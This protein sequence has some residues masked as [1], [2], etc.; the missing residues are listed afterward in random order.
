VRTTVIFDFK[1][2]DF[3][4]DPAVNM[5]P[6]SRETKA[7]FF[8]QKHHDRLSRRAQ[9]VTLEIKDLTCFVKILMRLLV[10]KS[11]AFNKNS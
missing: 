2:I 3:A 6:M 4:V 8:L 7:S 10:M 1:G 9:N 11:S 5:L